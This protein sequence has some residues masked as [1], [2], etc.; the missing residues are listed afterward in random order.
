MLKLILWLLFIVGILVFLVGARF[1]WPLWP[2]LG[3]GFGL[4]TPLITVAYIQATY[5]TETDHS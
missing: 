5:F 4:I 3:W 1:V 2:T